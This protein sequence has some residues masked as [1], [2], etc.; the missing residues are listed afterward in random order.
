[1]VPTSNLGAC[2]PAATY[3]SGGRAAL[4]V[5]ST[6][7][8]YCCTGGGG[9]CGGCGGSGG[10]S[11]EGAVAVRVDGPDAPPGSDPAR[12]G[13][14]VGRV[15]GGLKQASFQVSYLLSH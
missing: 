4:G 1:M 2:G 3:A 11:E 12:P 8:P 10:G 14:V 5:L 13:R 9:G 15:Q 7:G 6:G